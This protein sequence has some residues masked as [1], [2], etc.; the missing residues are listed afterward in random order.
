MSLPP[1]LPPWPFAATGSG[2]SSCSS[3]NTIRKDH[4]SSAISPHALPVSLRSKLEPACRT[5]SPSVKVEM[6]PFAALKAKFKSKAA[7]VVPLSPTQVHSQ[8]KDHDAQPEAES[9]TIQSSKSV[10]NGPANHAVSGGVA[11]QSASSLSSKSAVVLPT[12]PSIAPVAK[13]SCN[14]KVEAASDS[15]F[16]A[17]LTTLQ[18]PMKA[19]EVLGLPA[20]AAPWF[21][22][23]T[24]SKSAG[25][26]Q[27]THA[28]SNGAA[29]LW[30]SAPNSRY[31]SA[32]PASASPM[33]SSVS[34][35][36]SGCAPA[37]SPASCVRST[38]SSSARAAG[39]RVELPFL[40]LIARSGPSRMAGV[41]PTD[42]LEAAD[43][44]RIAENSSGFAKSKLVGSSVGT[45]L[46]NAGFEATSMFALGTSLLRM[47][48]L[49][50]KNEWIIRHQD[51]FDH[52]DITQA[53]KDE[54][55][56]IE[57]KLDQVLRADLI[58]AIDQLENA[59]I[60][61][62]AE[63]LRIVIHNAMQASSL[64]GRAYGQINDALGKVHCIKMRL[65]AEYLQLVVDCRPESC[66]YF[67][68][69]AS[70]LLRKLHMELLIQTA[71]EEQLAN[72]LSFRKEDRLHMLDELLRVDRWARDA[73]DTCHRIRLQA[74]HAESLAATASA[75]LVTS[76]ALQPAPASSQSRE[77]FGFHASPWCVQ[78]TDSS[79]CGGLEEMRTMDL[80]Q[81]HLQIY[82]LNYS[83][84]SLAVPMALSS[85]G[86]KPLCRLSPTR[87]LCA[88]VMK[89]GEP[90]S[91]LLLQLRPDL[92]VGSVLPVA[93]QHAD[94]S[95]W[96][97]R[98]ISHAVALS[99]CSVYLAAHI[100]KE[101]HD[102]FNAHQAGVFHLQ[103]APE[104]IHAS[105]TASTASGEVVP[106]PAAAWVLQQVQEIQAMPYDSD[107]HSQ[108]V[109]ERLVRMDACT[110]AYSCPRH[111][112]LNLYRIHACSEQC[113]MDSGAISACTGVR[114]SKVS[115]SLAGI[116]KL[117]SQSWQY[118]DRQPF[119][120]NLGKKDVD[121]VCP[122][123]LL[124]T[125][126][127]STI[128]PSS[129]SSDHVKGLLMIGNSLLAVKLISEIRV[130]DITGCDHSSDAAK[131]KLLWTSRCLHAPGTV[132]EHFRSL[133]PRLL[134]LYFTHTC[135]IWD[136][137]QNRLISKFEVRAEGYQ[138][139]WRSMPLRWSTDGARILVPRPPTKDEPAHST[140][141]EVHEFA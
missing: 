82:L 84:H 31:V 35:V 71:V 16:A 99:P 36:E 121:R 133:S 123:A 132:L 37:A 95:R 77:L 26:V 1:I 97:V 76:N 6:T 125:I 91:L 102:D 139:T 29:V 119:N 131:P 80:L 39:S 38:R 93:L 13:A 92:S 24:S 49:A 118:A 2:A 108:T 141:F 136:W 66:A 79:L 47:M 62:E 110:L 116:W 56:R 130:Y 44:A 23:K 115:L 30:A 55:T 129:S 68:G 11:V 17:S 78:L 140:L 107:K 88:R 28:V 4:A 59:M 114:L 19:K 103:L 72:R 94:G 111:H 40:S 105:A 86:V 69:L 126:L 63:D 57:Q 14:M 67:A 112:L 128:V 73:F 54:L 134:L 89:G 120:C 45:V 27:T 42:G 106:N 10:R 53:M 124:T 58:A 41:D 75:A 50:A 8:T 65:A 34:A 51:K 100:R 104:H 138:E 52:H 46:A 43:V 12:F 22:T 18:S 33:L 117:F 21:Y 135:E 83:V 15:V 3:H 70:K 109:C 48:F 7:A 122:Q 85:H 74:S 90:K 101:P 113:G 60:A 64:L 25:E 137:Q 20:A 9:V 87:L 61:Y 81:E 96:P 98:A 127:P 5:D 32:R